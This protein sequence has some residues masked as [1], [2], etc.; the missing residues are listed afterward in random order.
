MLETVQRLR[1]S[2]VAVLDLGGGE[3]D[4]PTPR[5]IA[6]EASAALAEGFTH[7]TPSRGLPELRQVIARKLQQDNGITVD[8]ATDV[9]VTPSAKHALFVALM[10]V[11]DPGDELIVPTPAWVSYTPMAGLIGAR[12]VPAELRAENDFRI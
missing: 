2:G 9:I 1:A 10:T 5:H 7:Y 6:A 11:L 3:P 12:T 8:P 4:F